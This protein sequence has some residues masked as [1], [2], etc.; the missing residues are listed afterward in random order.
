MAA[1]LPITAAI[2]NTSDSGIKNEMSRI[3]ANSYLHTEYI[4]KGKTPPQQSGS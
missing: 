2:M 3:F 4:P 1:I